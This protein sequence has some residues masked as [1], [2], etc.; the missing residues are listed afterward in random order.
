MHPMP[1]LALTEADTLAVASRLAAEASKG[2]IFLLEGDLGAGKTAFARAF[3]RSLSG[4]S[5]QEV[6]SPT[7]TLLQTYDTPQGEVWHFDLYRLKDPD[8]IFELGWEDALAEGILLIE[9]PDR[10]G[11]HRPARC[12]TIRLDP[13]PGQPSAR[14]ITLT[15]ER[16]G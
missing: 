5:G 13:V 7:F 9:W 15:D 10:L 14:S 12:I 1:I 8:E 2:D 11:P 4:D 16:A 3:I 6:P